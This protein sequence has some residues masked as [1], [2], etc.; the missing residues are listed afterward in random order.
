MATNKHDYDP[1]SPYYT[2]KLYGPYLDTLEYRPFT[3]RADDVDYQIEAGYAY[4]PQKLAYDLYGDT[5]L[6]WVFAQR[7]PD[8]LVNPLL[9]FV[10]GTWIKVPYKTTLVDDLGI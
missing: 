10:P 9:D 4:R 6:W 3:Y 7:N 8:T 1:T 5:R 2:T